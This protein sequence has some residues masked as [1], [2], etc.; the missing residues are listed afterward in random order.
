MAQSNTPSLELEYVLDT[1][2]DEV[3]ILLVL[4]EGLP[5]CLLDVLRNLARV[6]LHSCLL[7]DS[8]DE[9]L[10]LI[11]PLLQSLHLLVHI[12]IL[13]QGHEDSGALA[14]G[15]STPCRDFGIRL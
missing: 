7:L 9:S 2:L 6:V 5:M 10:L 1:L 3:V 8:F 11:Q 13:L 14:R 15:L 12:D 4:L